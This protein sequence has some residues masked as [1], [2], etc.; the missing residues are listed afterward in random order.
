M[1][2]SRFTSKLGVI[3]LSIVLITGIFLV[4]TLQ[5]EVQGRGGGKQPAPPTPGSIASPSSIPAPPT[6]GTTSPSLPETTPPQIPTIIRRPTTSSNLDTVG[7]AVNQTAG[8]GAVNQSAIVMIPQSSVM[9][10]MSNLQAAMNAVANDNK[11]EA[12]TVLN[13]VDQELKSAA[14]ASDMSIGN[15]TDGVG[16]GEG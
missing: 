10:I 8:G 16:G 1:Q 14:N 13:S 6:P 9:K 12:M 11:D 4:P 15:T 5:I 3:V 2:L 7:A